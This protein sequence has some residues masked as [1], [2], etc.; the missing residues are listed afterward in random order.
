MLTTLREIE[1]CFDRWEPER[2]VWVAPIEVIR[3]QGAGC[4]V[5]GA[6]CKAY[7]AGC[8]VQGGSRLSRYLPD[9]QYFSSDTHQSPPVTYQYSPDNCQ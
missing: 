1:F 5:Q 8:K 9:S 7:G 6:G 4:R 3:V 2:K